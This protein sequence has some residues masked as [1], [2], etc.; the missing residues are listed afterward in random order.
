MKLTNTE[1][2]N[3]FTILQILRCRVRHLKHHL[4]D[5]F[6]HYF[7]SGVFVS[8]RINQLRCAH[9]KAH[10][11]FSLEVS[12]LLHEGVFGGEACRLQEVEQ[13]EELLHCVLEGSTRQQDLVLLKEDESLNIRLKL[14]NLAFLI[15]ICTMRYHFL[16]AHGFTCQ[17]H[18]L[19]SL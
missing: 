17:V 12:K 9:F 14:E 8:C 13:A 4:Q 11:L 16:D 7:L 2:N 1:R 5:A 6:V 18:E 15:E 10:L 19:E 3:L